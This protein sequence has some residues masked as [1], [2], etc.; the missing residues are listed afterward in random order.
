MTD[1]TLTNEVKKL[2]V[3]A[4][5]EFAISHIPNIDG[6]TL[7]KFLDLVNVTG[8]FGTINHSELLE[9]MMQIQKFIPTACA[10]S[11]YT[12]AEL[13]EVDFPKKES[14]ADKVVGVI[15]PY[16]EPVLRQG[17]WH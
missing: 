6:D 3:E 1:A 8:N 10:W 14:V 16:H 15:T 2:H 13:L 9:K 17:A 4:T 12:V 11:L 7:E 5:V